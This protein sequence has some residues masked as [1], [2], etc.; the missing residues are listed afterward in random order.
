VKEL[1]QIGPVPDRA[2]E[3]QPGPAVAGDHGE[4]VPVH[5]D[6]PR[7]DVPGVVAGR[8]QLPVD[9]LADLRGVVVGQVDQQVPFLGVQRVRLGLRVLVG[10]DVQD[11]IF[12][13]EGGLPEGVLWGGWEGTS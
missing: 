1:G 2:G 11:G 4:P 5:A 6:H 10:V 12:P 9:E 13:G 7:L 3:R 8:D